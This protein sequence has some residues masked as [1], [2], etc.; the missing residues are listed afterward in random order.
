MP[1]GNLVARLPLMGIAVKEENFDVADTKLVKATEL[2]EIDIDWWIQQN[3]CKVKKRR[4]KNWRRQS[5]KRELIFIPFQSRKARN[6]AER[7]GKRAAVDLVQDEDVRRGKSQVRSRRKRKDFS[8]GKLD[9]KWDDSKDDREV[10]S[11]PPFCL[12]SHILFGGMIVMWGAKTMLSLSCS[13]VRGR[14]R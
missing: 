10:I 9:T 8:R 1:V 12:I 2:E 6:R 3:R 7:C 11:F 13:M 4:H 5:R 14:I